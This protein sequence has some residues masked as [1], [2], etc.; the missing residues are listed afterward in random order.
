MAKKSTVELKKKYHFLT[1][2]KKEKYLKDTVVNGISNI[3]KHLWNAPAFRS[4]KIYISQ[5]ASS[6]NCSAY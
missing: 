3:I 5:A 2:I 4:S 6:L 1:S